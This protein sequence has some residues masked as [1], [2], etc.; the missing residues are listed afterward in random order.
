MFD[1]T[2]QIK[3]FCRDNLTL[4]EVQAFN[5]TFCSA[6]VQ[7]CHDPKFRYLSM[8]F[9]CIT[10]YDLNALTE[11]MR[12]QNATIEYGREYGYDKTFEI[13][14]EITLPNLCRLGIFL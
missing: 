8:A 3:T 11:I 9:H 2:A 12:L 10:L 4:A 6:D 14:G 7:A 13:Y 5:D 1:V